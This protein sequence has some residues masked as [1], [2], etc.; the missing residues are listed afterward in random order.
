VELVETAETLE[1]IQ[2]EKSEDPAPAEP[3]YEQL[4]LQLAQA[5]AQVV[6][7]GDQLV[8]AIVNPAWAEGLTAAFRGLP[9]GMIPDQL[10]DQLPIDPDDQCQSMQVITRMDLENNFLLQYYGPREQ[11]GNGYLQELDEYLERNQC[12]VRATPEF[13]RSRYLTEVSQRFAPRILT[14]GSQPMVMPGN[15]R[16]R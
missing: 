12:P 4:A 14:P 7:S 13:L 9:D 10:R 15:L 3:N 5:T 11:G 8:A 1:T 2:I 16:G 6:R